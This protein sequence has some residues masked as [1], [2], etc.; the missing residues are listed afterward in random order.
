M[1]PVAI[2][3]AALFLCADYH[4]WRKFFRDRKSLR[5]AWWIP[6]ALL[7]LCIVGAVSGMWHSFFMRATYTLVFV[8]ALPML[9]F[10]LF[11][12]LLGKKA[13]LLLS[14]SV[15]LICIYG[16]AVGF[17]RLVITETSVECHDL[18]AAFDGYRIVHLSDFHLGSYMRHSKMPGRVAGLVAELKPDMVVFTGDLVNTDASEAEAFSASLSHIT[19]PDGVYSV[20]GN[21]DYGFD[22]GRIEESFKELCSIEEKAGWKMLNNT[23][24]T[25]R[26]GAD[27]LFVIG[28]ENTSK[29]FFISRGNLQKAL[30]GIPE[31]AF[32]ILLTHDPGHWRSE[33]LP[34]SDIQLTLSGHT[35]AMQFKAFGLS[36]ARLVFKEWSGLYE[37]SGRSLY[38]SEG[39]GGIFPFRFGSYPQISVLTLRKKQTLKEVP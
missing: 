38:V 24:T 19:A 21:H 32:K 39:I 8:F 28:V 5:T 23:G 26:R 7:F 18:P 3:T 15:I 36:P 35:H 4:L 10:A 20:S 22:K 29:T 31:G 25:I 14:A 13:S 11:Y 33:V 27:S 1:L 12:R 9:T 37:A 34:A 17:H 30:E 6:T 16:M 2:I